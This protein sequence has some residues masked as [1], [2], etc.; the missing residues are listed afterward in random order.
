MQYIRN[1]SDLTIFI[2]FGLILRKKKTSSF[3]RLYLI[4]MTHYMIISRGPRWAAKHGVVAIYVLS[5]RCQGIRENEERGK[6]PSLK[7]IFR[8]TR[9][10]IKEKLY[11]AITR[12]LRETDHDQ[13][14][15]SFL[16]KFVAQSILKAV[17]RPRSVV[18][19][20]MSW[21]RSW[22]ARFLISS[23]FW[24]KTLCFTCIWNSS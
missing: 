20:N 3:S 16:G 13:Y 2:V 19:S 11:Q 15:P 9:N 12:T 6:S 1:P 24:W 23:S 21:R 14:W 7:I 5:S 10:Q 4:T 18:S 17:I 22:F 8:R